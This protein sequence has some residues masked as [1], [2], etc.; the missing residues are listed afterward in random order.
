MKVLAPFH[1]Q[2]DKA[3][4]WRYGPLI[5][6]VRLG[7]TSNEMVNDVSG[8]GGMTRNGRCYAS[9]LMGVGQEKE[10]VKDIS[11]KIAET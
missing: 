9:G 8:V 10:N 7:N 11:T 2:K 6:P 5:I 3:V 1:Y 4:P